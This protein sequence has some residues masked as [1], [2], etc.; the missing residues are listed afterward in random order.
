MATLA[1]LPTEL[2]YMIMS[3]VSYRE[4]ARMAL[5][6]R[7]CRDIAD[8]QE[9]YGA[10]YR[11]DFGDPTRQFHYTGTEMAEEVSWKKA[12]ERRH[13]AELPVL[14]QYRLAMSCEA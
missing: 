12:Y 4:R 6:S 13:F 8:D 1:S 3:L 5:V 7:L 9:S 14:V 10:Q 11:R 2:F